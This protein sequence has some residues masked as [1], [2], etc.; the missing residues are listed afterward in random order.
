MRGSSV[1]I[2]YPVWNTACV[3]LMRCCIRCRRG[4]AGDLVSHRIQLAARYLGRD[5]I[6]TAS[7]FIADPF[8]PGERMYRTG[9]VARW[10]ETA[11]W[12]ISGVVIDAKIRGH[13]N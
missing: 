8:T 11:R 3:F 6:W 4:V 13:G 1:P 12:S 5:R 2:G 7:R 9:D 10:L